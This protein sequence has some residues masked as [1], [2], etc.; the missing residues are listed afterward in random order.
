MD[1]TG[2]GMKLN[3]A[4]RKVEVWSVVSSLVFLGIA[5]FWLDVSI[6]FIA[7]FAILTVFSFFG[8]PVDWGRRA[9]S[10]LAMTRAGRPV[11]AVPTGPLSIGDHFEVSYEQNWKR[12]TEV[13]RIVVQLVLRETVRYTSGN[14]THTE[15]HDEVV[16]RHETP[17]R[18]FQAGEVFGETY[19]FQIRPDGMHTFAPSQDNR[20]EWY[21]LFA[22]ELSQWPDLQR[23]YEIQVQP[24]VAGVSDG[25]R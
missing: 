18:R 7:I 23:E 14:D 12:A 20:I 24:Q 22:V 10:G 16:Q 3:V 21:V 17:G 25:G 6:G 4:G 1:W 15:R 11:V 9:R 19:A 13:D 2:W 8:S 5:I